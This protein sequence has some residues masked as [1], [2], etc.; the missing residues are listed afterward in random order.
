M[1]RSYP[2]GKENKEL[3]MPGMWGPGFGWYGFGMMVFWVI[4]FL[5]LVGLMVWAIARGW[6]NR[7][8]PMPPGTRS[9]QEGPSALE[10]LR[11]RYARGE[12]DT[13]TYEAMRERLEAP[14]ESGRP[15]IP[16]T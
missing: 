8:L 6:Q 14:G 9:P 1:L 15:P 7:N 12:I 5:A 16:S 3:S 4:V 13:A 10:V 2:R 11:R